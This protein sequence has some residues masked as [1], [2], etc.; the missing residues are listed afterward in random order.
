MAD[1]Q[2]N[3]PISRLTLSQ[4]IL[5]PIQ[6]L[7]AAQAHASRSFLNLLLQT[8][9]DHK[10]VGKDGTQADTSGTST[11]KKDLDNDGIYRLYFDQT[12]EVNGKKEKIRVSIPTIA[13]V[14]MHPLT[15]DEAEIEFSMRLSGERYRKARTFSSASQ[16]GQGSIEDEIYNENTRPWFLID[17]PVDIYGEIAPKSNASSEAP[18]ISVKIK[19]KQCETPEALRRFISNLNDFS[20]IQMEPQTPDTEDKDN[21]N[22][23]SA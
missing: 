12:R 2:P 18:E 9:F 6:S 8:G 4:A 3:E 21:G 10:G 22:N 5:A 14:P 20:T 17:D 13:A 1:K 15:I 11:G 23:Q 7:L 16:K 19:V